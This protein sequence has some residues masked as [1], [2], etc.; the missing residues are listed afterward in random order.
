MAML[1][2]APVSLKVQYMYNNTGKRSSEG[3]R[4]SL[5]FELIL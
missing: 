3:E 5:L 1:A 2:H 4:V